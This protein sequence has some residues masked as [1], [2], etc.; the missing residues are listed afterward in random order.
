MKNEKIIGAGFHHI[1]IKVKD[2]DESV[3]FYTEGLGFCAIKSWGSGN[4]RAVMLDIGGGDIME[5]FA[6]GN[7]ELNRENVWQHFAI[8]V[9]DVDQAYNCA[10]KAG[11]GIVRTPETVTLDSKPE[12]MTIRV[13]FVSG[14]DGEQLEFFKVI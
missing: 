10:L 4:E 7:E 11:A 9:D 8:S 13:A 5:M 14:P 1:G 3:K 12:K 2:F 6:G